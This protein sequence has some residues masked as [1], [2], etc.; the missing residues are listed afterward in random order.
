[1]YKQRFK[2][3][4]IVKH[5]YERKK[6]LDW[7]EKTWQKAQIKRYFYDLEQFSL[8]CIIVYYCLLLDL[9]R[10]MLVKMH[11]QFNDAFTKNMKKISY[12]I[13]KLDVYELFIIDEITKH[14]TVSKSSTMLQ[15]FKTIKKKCKLL[16]FENFYIIINKKVINHEKTYLMQ[17]KLS[18][19]N[20]KSFDN[21]YVHHCLK[22]GG[23]FNIKQNRSGKCEE[24]DSDADNDLYEPPLKKNK[25]N[26]S[27]NNDKMSELI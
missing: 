27:S 13:N 20:I 18:T 4:K 5:F 15:L 3:N 16:K 10:L 14:I 19:F 23:K 17:Q 22:G 21:I 26:D 2:H 1:M 11:Q 9:D 12:T 8:K 24:D 7:I 25:K 6:Q